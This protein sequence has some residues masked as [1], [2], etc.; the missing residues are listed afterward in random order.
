MKD[1]LKSVFPVPLAK[2]LSWNGHCFFLIL[3]HISDHY[4]INLKDTI[5]EI[6]CNEIIISTQTVHNTAFNF[7]SHFSLFQV[8]LK[9]RSLL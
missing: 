3:R 8:P 2:K 4:I 1:V 5:F 7:K 9:K 6:R